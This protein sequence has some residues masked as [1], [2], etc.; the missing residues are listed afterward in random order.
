MTAETEKPWLA[1][2]PADVRSSLSYSPEPLS[3]L[4]DHAAERFGSVPATLFYGG[5]LTWEEVQRTSDA[6]AVS[7][8]E[9]GVQR[10]DRVAIM[11]PNVPQAV[12][13]YFAVLKLGALV[14]FFNPLY[15]ER[16]IEHQLKD[17]GAEVMVVLDLLYERVR[18]V[19]SLTCLNRVVVTSLR[20]YMGTALRLL[21]P[22]V[23]RELVGKVPPDPDVYEF[24]D[25]VRRHDGHAPPP[26]KVDPVQ[27]VAVLQYTGGTTGLS[28]G[29]MLTHQ[30]LMA[31]VR[32]VREW[33]PGLAEGGERILAVMP[34]FHVYGLT[35]CL[36]LAALI[37]ATLILVPK[38][39]L[40]QVLQLIDKQKP[41]LFPGAPP[42]YVAINHAPDVGKYNLR[43]I[44]ACISGAAA[45][46]V[47]VQNQF[48]ALTGGKLVE[49]YG[50]TEASPVTH[51]NPIYGL[52]KP[53]SIGLPLPDTEVKLVDLVTGTE[54]VAAG[55]QGELCIRGPQ[56]MAGYWNRPEETAR[57]LRDGW[58]HT[59]DIARTD[60]DGYVAI[61]DRAKDMIIASGYNIFPR[62]VEEVLFEH[63]AV[64]EAVVAGIP[65]EY[66]GQ[67]VKA[68]IVLKPAITVTEEEI[69]A[70]CR[71]R[72]A[73]Y[74]V[75]RLVEFRDSLPKTMIG[76]VL[77]RVLLE[78]ERQR[79][80]APAE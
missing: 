36:N 53:G 43:S 73:R 68:Y 19:R 31:N 3:S 17:S 77:R 69:K 6:L 61:V 42:I 80:M 66:R 18:K 60:E 21:V 74:K 41:T 22:L 65:D 38:F 76:K 51:C 67:D 4:L 23:K 37:G 70:F 33:M 55:E 63:P 9:L 79:A 44:K 29:A 39:D 20:D 54:P 47:E 40:K 5:K 45:L 64:L 7:L 27:D 2:Y 71:E 50:L 12:I 14:V 75:P 72:M 57:V 13:A 34:F 1:H 59:G 25:L 26:L 24:R 10:G 28:K 32:Q 8:A 11:L 58:L 46:P 52:R 48:E 56:V 49:G 16:E 15:V 78:E 35:V 62:E 30:N